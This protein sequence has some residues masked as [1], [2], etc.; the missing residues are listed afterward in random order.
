MIG[1][2]GW[3]TA[4]ACVASFLPGGAQATLT[5]Y[6]TQAAF[7]AAATGLTS[8]AIPAPVG[9]NFQNVSP[10]IVIGPATFASSALYLQ[11][12]GGYGAGQTYLDSVNAALTM[13]LAGQTALGFDL[14]TFSFGGSEGGSFTVSVNG[15]APITV[16]T[17][18]G[19]PAHQFFGLI[20]TSPITS[21]SFSIPSTAGQE[22]DILDFQVGSAAATAAPEPATLALLTTGLLGLAAA[23]RRKAG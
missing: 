12:D 19:S 15:G 13:T 8:Y 23:R 11:N 21:L 5:S 22:L 2:K 16:T 1:S 7:I 6:D 18:S 4:A 3:G 10:S 20:D 17:A 14:G 9:A